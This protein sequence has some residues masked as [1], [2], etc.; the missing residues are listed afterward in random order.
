MNN[1]T[2]STQSASFDIREHTDKLESSGKNKTK[3]ICPVCNGRDLSI[4]F[5]TGAYQ[6]FDGCKPE[7]IREAIAP[8][9]GSNVQ[10][11]RRKEKQRPKSKAEI[12]KQKED[13]VGMRRIQL[14]VKASDLF[15]QVECGGL[16][17]GE[18][19]AEIAEWAKE[20]GYDQFA[21]KLL[22]QDKLKFLPASDTSV[23]G[24]KTAQT[25]TESLKSL[26]SQPIVMILIF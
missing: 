11:Q 4:S 19:I 15:W 7:D 9:Q 17:R 22:L 8:W 1:N 26:V 14:D 18:A 16:T 10:E 20:F 13:A 24:Q 21:A 6:C 23:T 2:E 12:I 3:F 5:K 25:Q